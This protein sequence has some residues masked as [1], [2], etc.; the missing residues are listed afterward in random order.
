[1]RHSGC[2]LATENRR[3]SDATALSLPGIKMKDAHNREPWWGVAS[4]KAIAEAILAFTVL[5]L[6]HPPAP[7]MTDVGLPNVLSVA[8]EQSR[9]PPLPLP[10]ARFFL[11]AS[12]DA[13]EGLRPEV[14][15]RGPPKQ[16]RNVRIRDRVRD[17]VPSR[18][19]DL[20]GR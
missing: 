11:D 10:L 12:N 9:H 16:Q 4:N 20:Q 19:A 7:Q 13:M 6:I 14:C 2:L 17:L 15:G 5:K 1:M 8:Q 18:D 3:L